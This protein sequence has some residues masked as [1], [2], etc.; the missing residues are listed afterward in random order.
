M[1][2]ICFSAAS[3]SRPNP[4]QTWYR[5]LFGLAEKDAYTVLPSYI[6]GESPLY[7]TGDDKARV[8]AVSVDDP[9]FHYAY[10]FVQ[11]DIHDKFHRRG[12]HEGSA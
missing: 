7:L 9:A 5:R 12:I 3:L 11:Q 8:E 10:K 4:Y 1:T 6:N 2:Q